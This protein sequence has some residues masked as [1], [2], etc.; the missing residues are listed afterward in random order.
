MPRRRIET[1][2]IDSIEAAVRAFPEGASI[3]QIEELLTPAPNRR[4]LQ[5]RLSKL[6]EAGKIGRKGKGNQSRYLPYI[7]KPQINSPAWSLG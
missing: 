3:Q 2:E 7:N 5:R 4:T 6:E 1:Q